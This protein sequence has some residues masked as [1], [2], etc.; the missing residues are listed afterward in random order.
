M[1][2][3]DSQTLGYVV[4]TSVTS[5]MSKYMVNKKKTKTN[6]QQ[7]EKQIEQNRIKSKI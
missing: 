5:K 7:T 1:S 4:Y 3:N 6:T 2:I